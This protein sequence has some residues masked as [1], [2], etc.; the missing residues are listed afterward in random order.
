MTIYDDLLDAP[1][2]KPLFN[3]SDCATDHFV[4]TPPERKYLTTGTVA[5]P[6]GVV[7]VLAGQGGSSK[8]MLSAGVSLALASGQPYLGFTPT[9]KHP[10][11]Y[12]SGEDDKNEIHRRIYKMLP[13]ICP[14]ESS[15]SGFDDRQA[16]T[17]LQ[18][19]YVPDLCGKQLRLTEKNHEV[20]QTEVF[21]SL[22]E[23]LNKFKDIKMIIL[24]T[25]SR[26]RG[27]SENDA[28][29]TAMFVSTCEQIVAATGATILII[30]HTNKTGGGGQN[31]TRGSSALVDNS[32]L[33]MTMTP[34]VVNKKPTN[35]VELRVAKNNYG[36][37]HNISIFERQDDGT[38]HLINAEDAHAT[39]AITSLGG[40]ESHIVSI[41]KE[42]HNS[43][44]PISIREFSREYGGV[45]KE[46][47]I[48]VNKMEKGLRALVQKGRLGIEKIGRGE[49]LIPVVEIM[50]TE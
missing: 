8:S 31:A 48:S 43:G 24:D 16:T 49:K 11:L 18:N 27:G 40:Y 22:M 38:L 36:S 25:G 12:L 2:A 5:I 26:F 19:L 50:E 13:G 44:D 30:T 46:F 45:N 37:A 32:R 35:Q 6:E 41:I 33:T 47:S 7:S 17:T 29:D 23:T 1:T 3:P 9:D 20:H 21:N 15:L 34:V 10:V 14:M 28:S 4:S 42:H 39:K